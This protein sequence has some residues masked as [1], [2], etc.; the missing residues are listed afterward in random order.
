MKKIVRFLKKSLKHFVIHLIFKEDL[1]MLNLKELT[2]ISN[3]I[4][5]EY[6]NVPKFLLMPRPGEAID[7]GPLRWEKTPLLK[8]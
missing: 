1:K 2:S 5:G 8:D 7:F 3:C 4:D 6:P